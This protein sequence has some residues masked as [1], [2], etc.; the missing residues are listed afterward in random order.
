MPTLVPRV[1]SGEGRDGEG[2]SGGKSS[3]TDHETK[4]VVVV[5]DDYLLLLLIRG[6]MMLSLVH[7]ARGGA[8]DV[9][10]ESLVPGDGA[11]CTTTTTTNHAFVSIAGARRRLVLLR[12]FG[13]RV[14]LGTMARNPL[15]RMRCERMPPRDRHWLGM[16]IDKAFFSTSTHR[17]RFARIDVDERERWKRQK[18]CMEYEYT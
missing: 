9:A 17:R 10:W 15:W 13:L 5:T 2:H 11:S 14:Q 4:R 7:F 1:A 16:G 8:K 12:L 6:M 3:V 18:V